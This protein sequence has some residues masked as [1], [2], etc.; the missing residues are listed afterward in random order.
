MKKR[1]EKL[2]PAALDAI[3]EILL[4]GD[5]NKLIDS[6]YQ[7][8]IS[9]FGASVMQMG[10]LPTLAVYADEGSGASR[11]RRK[12]LKIL[13]KVLVSSASSF[14][15]KQAIIA[16]GNDLF[17][18]AVQGLL[19]QSERNTLQEHLLDASV[20]VKLCLRTFKLTEK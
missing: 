10:M 6:E 3:D 12:L 18:T 9:S 5:E 17:K 1:I 11:D 16:H 19:S 13:A 15:Y 20:A 7:G 8:Y 14:Q 2:F 4:G